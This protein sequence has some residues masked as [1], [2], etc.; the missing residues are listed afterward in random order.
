[1]FKILLLEDDSALNLT[2]CMYLNKNGYEATGVLNAND[3]YDEMFDNVF[4]LIIS[5]IMMPD[6]DGFE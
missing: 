4:D 5:D 6:I 1:M 3:A 2:V